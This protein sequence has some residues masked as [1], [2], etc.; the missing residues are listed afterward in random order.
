MARKYT[1]V[2]SLIAIVRERKDRG[3]TN[4]EIG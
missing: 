4:K 3:E 2:E 1:K